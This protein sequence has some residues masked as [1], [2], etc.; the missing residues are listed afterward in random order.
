MKAL[1]SFFVKVDFLCRLLR[2]FFFR[3]AGANFQLI[4]RSLKF[5]GGH[6]IVLGKNIV[7]GDFCWF[8]AVSRYKGQEFKPK[9]CIGDSVAFSDA[10]HISCIG[11]ITIGEGCLFGS[12]IYVGDHSHGALTDYSMRAPPATRK[13]LDQEDI[14]IGANS[15]ICDGAV[16]LA[17]TIL[18]EGCVV[19]ANSVVKGLHVDSP[20]LIAGVPAKVIHYF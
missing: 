6:F 12:R 4:G 13:L 16:I 11:N 9:I 10:V 7:V 18:A 5:R 2:A 3:F 1:G 8:E 17:G 14:Y 19:G 20:A 15:W